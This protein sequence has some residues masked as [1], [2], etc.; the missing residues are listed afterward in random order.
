MIEPLR[1]NV[2]QNKL[3]MRRF[4]MFRAL[5]VSI[6]LLL[7]FAL[8]L[9]SAAALD[10]S[11]AYLYA[12]LFVALIESVVIIIIMTH[13]HT[14]GVRFSFLLLCADLT[15]ISAVVALTGGNRSMFAF[16]YIA[17][18][19]STSILLSFDWSLVIAT[20]SGV[21]FVV[22]MFLEANGYIVPAS[23]FRWQEPTLA[24]GDRWAYTGMK[25]LAFYLTAFLAGHLSRRVGQLQ[26]LQHNILNN[27][28]S[29]FISVNR[30]RIVTFLNPAGSA[31]LQ[32]SPSETVGTHVSKAFSVTG[33]QSNPLEDAIAEQKEC[34]SREI[35]VRRGDGKEVPV[36]VTVSLLR[37][38]ATKLIGAVA[39]FINLT[40]LK[41]MEE[42]LR[43]ADRMAAVG[44]MSTVLAHEI[45]N[46][47]ASIRGAIQELSENLRL[48]GADGRLME[49]AIRASDQL[50]KIV[51]DFLEFAGIT[52]RERRRF[53]VG[54]LL[55]EVVETAERRFACNGSIRIVRERLDEPGTAVGDRTQIKEAVLNVV[56]NGIEAMPCGGELRIRVLEDEES[57]ENV[58]IVIQ[59]TGNGLSRE[60]VDRIFDPFYTTKQDGV[61][62][63]MAV[64]HRIIASHG[65]TIDVESGKGKGTAVTIVLPRQD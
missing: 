51:S 6:L 37:N 41:R 48:D 58:S 52:P 5:I 22:M 25:I 10:L 35:M 42:R 13:G 43:R 3:V 31:L 1:T 7:C 62:L 55:E 12:I 59:D 17:A 29:G 16:L 27:F 44:E 2:E 57:S 38:S 19:L 8:H 30:D 49:I 33:G 34:Q 53:N 46:P 63:G 60:E 18:I 65:G 39:S 64:V 50:N 45:R 36:G 28:S 40:E 61:G 32:R 11:T 26:S 47:V 23:A 20:I 15:L 4:A 14:P 54:R 56:Q 24:P 21:L 9:R